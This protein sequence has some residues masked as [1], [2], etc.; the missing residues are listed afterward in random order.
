M[1]PRSNVWPTLL[2]E[3]LVVEPYKN[4][5]RPICKGGSNGWPQAT[6]SPSQP[7]AILTFSFFFT[8]HKRGSSGIAVATNYKAQEIARKCYSHKQEPLHVRAKFLRLSAT[9][10]LQYSAMKFVL[11]QK[12]MEGQRRPT[13][14]SCG[15]AVFRIGVT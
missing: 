3:V 12:Q 7:A 2:Y 5:L 10:S 9:G 8:H 11:V 6:Y 14:S 13:A 4:I 15:D 1:W